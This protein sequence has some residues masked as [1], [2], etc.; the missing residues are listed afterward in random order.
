MN[1]SLLVPVEVVAHE[2]HVGDGAEHVEDTGD[3][4]IEPIHL[5]ILP[6]PTSYTDIRQPSS[7]RIRPEAQAFDAT[8]V[9]VLWAHLDVEVEVEA[10]ERRGRAS[11]VALGGLGLFFGFFLRLVAEVEDGGAGLCHKVLRLQLEAR[12]LLAWVLQRLPVH[13]HESGGSQLLLLRLM[14]LCTSSTRRLCQ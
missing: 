4:H 10:L 9:Y 2:G 5:L 11:N 3:V 12:Q 8:S 6:H 7:M 1:W 13:R 14:L